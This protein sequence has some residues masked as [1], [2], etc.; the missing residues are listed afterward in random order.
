MGH[1]RKGTLDKCRIYRLTS[2]QK[3]PY[4]V[5]TEPGKPRKMSFCKKVSNSLEKSGKML[6]SIQ[7]KELFLGYSNIQDPCSEMGVHKGVVHIVCSL[8]KSSHVTIPFSSGKSQG[9]SQ[10]FCF[11]FSVATMS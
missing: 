9:K 6:R 3:C 1:L 2:F 8:L 7:I 10:K 5:A 4:M 11:S